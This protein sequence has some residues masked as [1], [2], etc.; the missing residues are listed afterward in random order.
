MSEVSLLYLG[1]GEVARSTFAF[2]HMMAHRNYWA[3]MAPLDRFSVIPYILDPLQDVN[4]PAHRWHLN[5]QRAHNDALDAVPQAYG[6]TAVGLNIGQIL[7]DSNL[8]DQEQLSWW[9]FQNHMEHYIANGT[10]L[11]GPTATSPPWTYPFW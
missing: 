4:Q 6:A 9:L 3:V 5:H 1:S 7:V 8:D 2:E 10:F 11:P